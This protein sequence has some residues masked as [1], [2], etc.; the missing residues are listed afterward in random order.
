[1]LSPASMI[2][3]SVVY[4]KCSLP[5]LLAGTY[6]FRE[7][8]YIC[9]PFYLHKLTFIY[10]SCEEILS[11]QNSD[12]VA[13]LILLCSTL[14]R[15][16]KKSG[17]SLHNKSRCSNTIKSFLTFRITNTRIFLYFQKVLDL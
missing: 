10:W 4:L 11:S 6:K 17:K 14:L 7:S 9:V 2:E 8:I 12:K 5:C 13:S 16:H 15:A 1:M 3:A